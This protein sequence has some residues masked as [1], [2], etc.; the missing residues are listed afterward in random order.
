VGELR[1]FSVLSLKNVQEEKTSSD[2]GVC[3][4]QSRPARQSENAERE[5]YRC[6]Y[7]GDRWKRKDF[8]RDNSCCSHE[9]Q[10]D[11]WLAWRTDQFHPSAFCSPSAGKASPQSQDLKMRE[12]ADAQHGTAI[13]L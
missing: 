10:P 3:R 5:E 1:T 9:C 4:E 6:W 7:Q 13:D 11:E 12:T 8:R 2:H